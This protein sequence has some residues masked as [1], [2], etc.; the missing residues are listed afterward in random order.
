MS[1]TTEPHDRPTDCSCRQ[2][3]DLPCAPCFFA[4]FDSVN[5]EVTDDE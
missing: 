2:S 3:V 5:P 1:E 4:G